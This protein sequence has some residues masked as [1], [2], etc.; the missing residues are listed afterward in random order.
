MHVITEIG[1]CP[2]LQFTLA[3]YVR[4]L[5]DC[6][7][8]LSIQFQHLLPEHELDDFKGGFSVELRMSLAE[9]R[10]TCFKDK[11]G[12]LALLIFLVCLV[13]SIDLIPCSPFKWETF[14]MASVIAWNVIWRWV[15]TYGGMFEFVWRFFL[16]NF[17]RFWFLGPY[18]LVQLNIYLYSLKN[19][20]PDDSPSGNVIARIAGRREFVECFS[21]KIRRMAGGWL[22][23]TSV[24]TGMNRPRQQTKCADRNL[25]RAWTLKVFLFEMFPLWNSREY[26]ISSPSTDKIQDYQLAVGTW[27]EWSSPPPKSRLNVASPFPLQHSPTGISCAETSSQSA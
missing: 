14:S 21:P 24:I 4:H 17:S 27:F 10:L 7:K 8:N 1:P 16:F 11:T 15:Y 26:L 3:W 23:M 13:D 25:N 6:P 9:K 18:R 22:N 5:F 12:P 2:F 20:L 19:S